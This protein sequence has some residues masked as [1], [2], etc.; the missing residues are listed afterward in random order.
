MRKRIGGIALAMA[1][2]LGMQ[3]CYGSFTLTRKLWKWNG[4][5]GNKFVNELVF[6]VCNILPV[7]PIAGFVDSIILNSVEFWSGKNPMN[8]KVITQG[9]KQV[10]MQYDK[11]SGLVHVSVF[12]K[13][14][15][16]GQM[17]MKQTD[18][19]IVAVDSK[20]S[21]KVL[22]TASVGMDGKAFLADANGVVVAQSVQ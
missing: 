14:K 16:T 12:E 20:D 10:S 11:A 9:D 3:G 22:Y 2:V 8:A 1:L 13:G 21:S 6:L 19:G 4:S 7:Y 18:K 5:V 15:L 17:A